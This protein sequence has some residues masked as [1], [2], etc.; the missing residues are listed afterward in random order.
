MIKIQKLFKNV[1]MTFKLITLCKLTFIPSLSN[2]YFQLGINILLTSLILCKKQLV[3]IYFFKSL[4][5]LYIEIIT[6]II[7]QPSVFKLQSLKAAA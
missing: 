1:K 6:Q 2:C 4:V 7:T 5:H 3:S